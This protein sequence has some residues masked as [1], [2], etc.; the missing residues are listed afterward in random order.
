[1]SSRS[2]LIC[3]NG[4]SAAI[5]LSAL[6]RKGQGSDV[7]VTVIGANGQIGEGVAYATANPNHLLNVPVSRMSADTLQPD[8]FLLWLKK[9]GIPTNGWSGQFVPR[10]LY[11]DYLS[12][13]V[14]GLLSENHALRVRIQRGEVRSLVR[15]RAGWMVTHSGGSP[16]LADIV[17]LA[18]GNDMPTPI[19]G[20]YSPDIA[21]RIIDNPWTEIDVGNAD[22]VLILGTALTA[23]DAVISLLDR[24]HAGM[25]HL[26]SR[27][28]LLP[29]AHVEPAAV[30]PLQPPYPTTALGLT[31]AL[32]DAAGRIPAQWQG[33][34]D[35]MRPHW[36]DVWQ[37]LC[38]AEKRRFLRHAATQWT[39]HRHRIAPQIAERIK[40][41][42]TRNVRI[43]K[44][45]LQ[46]L[47]REGNNTL[48]ATIAHG[49]TT[50]L[51]RVHRIINC[52]GPNTDP[53]KT[54]DPFIENI[55]ASRQARSSSVGIGLDV[56]EKN[57]VRD[58]EG[59]VQPSLFAMGALTRGRWW[60]ISAIP[61]I[62]G[63]AVSIAGHIREQLGLLDAA[64]R[65]N[66][67]ERLD[68]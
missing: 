44:G 9:K 36:P 42:M 39:A 59:I 25:I 18:T 49:G 1:M 45:R 16:L 47:T 58:A 64:T 11:A 5:L 41:A 37:G 62:S 17:V 15:N 22:D 31:M 46:T 12:S 29:A 48:N 3:G 24:G 65:V 6:A 26:L 27:H 52:T 60:E 50:R 32:R 30:P 38:D 8:Q 66:Q 33:L 56:D 28:C 21:H 67:P 13:L 55:I 14:R 53:G 63:Q 10:T 4:A 61:E 34:M 68:I 35:A 40:V 57:R 7:C 20:R 51:L 23:M 2:I 43:L 54:H 19:A